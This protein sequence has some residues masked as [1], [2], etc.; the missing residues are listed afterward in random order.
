MTITKPVPGDVSDLKAGAAVVAKFGLYRGWYIMPKSMG[1]RLTLESAIVITNK[2][3]TNE[4]M[5]SLDRVNVKAEPAAEHLGEGEAY[6]AGYEEGE[7][8]PDLSAAQPEAGN[9]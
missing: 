2:C 3:E 5:P 7:E 6:E 9:P 1:G 8:A 4:S